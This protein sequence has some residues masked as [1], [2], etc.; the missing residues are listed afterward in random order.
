MN[1]ERTYK[2]SLI[3]EEREYLERNTSYK[4]LSIKYTCSILDMS[5]YGIYALRNVNDNKIYVGQTQRPFIKRWL[6]HQG[7]LLKELGDTYLSRAFRKYGIDP[8]CFE[9]LEFMPKELEEICDLKNI[10]YRH[11]RKYVTDKDCIKLQEWLDEKEQFYIAKF[12]EELGYHSVYNETSGGRNGIPT[13][14]LTTRRSNTLRETYTQERKDAISKANRKRY[15]DPNERKKTSESVRNAYQ[16]P[17]LKQRISE[18]RKGKPKS[19]K[20]KDSARKAQQ[21]RY[22][23]PNE[24]DKISI[25]IKRSSSTTKVKES[26]SKGQKERFKN[27]EQRNK[28][29][30]K[31]KGREISWSDKVASGIRDKW[32]DPKYRERILKSRKEN[33]ARIMRCVDFALA[34]VYMLHPSLRYTTKKHKIEI[35]NKILKIIYSSIHA[36][37]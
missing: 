8:F 3:R 28:I 10:S 21:K 5:H 36:L 25:G 2:N 14:E 13:F 6:E 20:W 31:L 35:M 26:R 24:H 9:I 32:K 7:Y 22:E 30:D 34:E 16:N 19:D 11:R 15:E 1:L 33:A 17:E 23:D 29:S 37:I 27:Q 18:Q 12:R 4:I